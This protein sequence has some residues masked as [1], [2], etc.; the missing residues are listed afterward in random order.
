MNEQQGATMAR[1]YIHLLGLPD[2]RLAYTSTK[3]TSA[4]VDLLFTGHRPSFT[5]PSQLSKQKPSVQ[6]HAILIC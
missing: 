3:V 5:P 6:I 4:A 1:V 2:L